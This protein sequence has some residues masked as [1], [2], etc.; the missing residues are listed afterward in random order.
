VRRVHPAPRERRHPVLR[1]PGAAVEGKQ[2][3][4]IESLAAG[5]TLHKVQQ[6]WLEYQ[7]PQCG[8]CL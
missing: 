7:A 8:Y 3:T 2:I 5:G 4:T 6:A 1:V